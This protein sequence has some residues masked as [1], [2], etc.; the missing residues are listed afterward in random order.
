MESRLCPPCL[1]VARMPIGADLCLT[2]STLCTTPMAAVGSSSAEFGRSTSQ[3]HRT[4]LLELAG[5][6]AELRE[7][8]FALGRPDNT[9]LTDGY[10]VR[11][12][13]KNAKNPSWKDN[14]RPDECPCKF[15]QGIRPPTHRRM[16][17]RSGFGF[18]T[19]SGADPERPNSG[20]KRSPHGKMGRMG[21]RLPA[22]GTS[23][24]NTS[25]AT[26]RRPAAFGTRPPSA[27]PCHRCPQ[28]PRTQ[29]RY[30]VWPKGRHHP[31][32]RM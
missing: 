7:G 31:P 18:G 21:A 12:G 3:R 30:R 22:Q 28:G 19:R 25:S 4:K 2:W 15:R 32:E 10:I 9:G 8:R 6:Q 5:N 16:T 23:A 1:Q 14:L 24:P 20:C 26:R 29:G 27:T 11:E 17:P 13:T